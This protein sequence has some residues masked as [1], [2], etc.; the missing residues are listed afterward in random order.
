MYKMR[1]LLIG[2]INRF[3]VS[4]CYCLLLLPIM[5]YVFVSTLGSSSCFGQK[6]KTHCKSHVE[7]WV[8]GFSLIFVFSVYL[9]DSSLVTFPLSPP[10]PPGPTAAAA[11]AQGGAGAQGPSAWEKHIEVQTTHRTNSMLTVKLSEGAGL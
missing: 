1:Y 2:Y 10:S 8:W 6:L 4:Y 11:V 3:P 5:L 7:S 9:R